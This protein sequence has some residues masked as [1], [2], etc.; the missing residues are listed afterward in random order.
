MNEDHEFRI[1]EKVE[2]TQAKASFQPTAM[3]GFRNT[4]LKSERLEL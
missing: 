3:F 2:F 1:G 4:I